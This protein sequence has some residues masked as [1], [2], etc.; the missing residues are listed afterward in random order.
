MAIDQRSRRALYEAELAARDQANMA[1]MDRAAADQRAR[2]SAF[3]GNS[4][5]SMMMRRY[6]QQ[7]AMLM[8]AQMESKDRGFDREAQRELAM[9][10]LLA[11]R[12]DRA[13]DRTFQGSMFDRKMQHESG[14]SEAERKARFDALAATLLAQKSEGEAG[15]SHAATLQQGQIAANQA[16]TAA[17]L[18][19]AEKARLAEQEFEGKYRSTPEQA[20]KLAQQKAM[21]EASAGI[22]AN[23][24]I[25]LGEIPQR[26][27]GLGIGGATAP[28]PK[29]KAQEVDPQLSALWTPLAKDKSMGDFL[30]SMP[31]SD[32]QNNREQMLKFL[33]AAYAGQKPGEEL[34]ARIATDNKRGKVNAIRGALGE[35]PVG[36]S[37]PLDL[38][39]SAFNPL[40]TNKIAYDLLT[41]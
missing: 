27:G 30:E 28:A 33:E 35:K 5:M 31:V 9:S 16:N 32:I 39:I 22:Y 12:Q 6:P 14:M 4:D 17:Q 19:A 40:W 36:G 38:L 2:M 26:L 11:R 7:A 15:R 10:E 25:P 29:T 1:G 13:E 20:A 24:D 8:A 41:Q 23:P 3:G 34:T 37:S 18:A 21:L